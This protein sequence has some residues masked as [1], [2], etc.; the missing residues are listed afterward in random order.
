MYPSISA[1]PSSRG[2]LA[3]SQARTSSR[4]AFSGALR[5]KSTS[6][7]YPPLWNGP[8]RDGRNHLLREHLQRVPIVEQPVLEHEKVNSQAPELAHPLC[9]LLGRPD[10]PGFLAVLEH[11]LGAHPVQVVDDLADL[12]RTLQHLGPVAADEEPG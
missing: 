3:F 12:R 11:L 9:D 4:N 10:K 2:A 6:F 5:S 7:P 1:P 8:S